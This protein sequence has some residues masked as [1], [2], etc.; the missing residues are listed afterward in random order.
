MFCVLLRILVEVVLPLCLD[1]V[2]VFYSPNRL[3]HYHKIVCVISKTLFGE[4]YPSA[5][6]QSVYSTAPTDRALLGEVLPLSSDA[7][8]V[9]YNHNRLGPHWGSL[10][11]LQRFSRC[12]L[13][14]QQTKPSLGKSHPSAQM[15]SVYSTTTTNS[16][17]TGEVLP[18]CRDSVGVFYSHNRLSPPWVSLTPQ[19]RCSRCI[20]QPQQTRPSLGKSYPSAKIQSVYSTAPMDWAL[21]GEVLPLC[22]DAVGV[23]YNHNKLGPHWGS[24]TPLQ[25]FSRC[26]LQPQQTKP[27]LGKSHPSAQM[28]SVYSTTTTNSALTGEVLPLCRDSVGVFYSHNRLSPPWVSLTP[29]LRCSRCILQPQQTRPSLGKSY[30]SA[31]IQSVYSTAPM[32]W[33]LLGEVLPLCRDA[34]GVFYN[35]N[36][37]GPHWGSL[38]PLQRFS[39]CILQ[40]QQTKPSLGKSHP[41][42]QM[43]S[44]YS[45]T[46][47]NSALT[48]EVLPLCRDSVGVFY[49]HNRLSPPW[50]SLTPQLRCSRCILQPQQTRPSLGKSYPYAEIQSVYSTTTTDSA[51]TGEVLPLCKDSVGVFYSPNGLG[52]PWGSLTPLQ[53]C[54][55]CILQ[56]QQTRPSLGKSYPSAEIQSVYSTATTD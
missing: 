32:D 2:G 53:R 45:T 31:K 3:G 35:H 43:Q 17:L 15:Q 5:E 34:V 38:T 20:L 24:L 6:M 7:V 22:R 13:Q 51:L 56:P 30:P 42:A 1:V 21:L 8:G 25:R 14:P 11:P 18:L 36:K 49:S 33:A 39:R 52:S 23:F 10:T 37:L 47:T 26:I 54:S 48:G 27:S 50:V 41:S 46:T 44:V 9:F 29:Q 55:R 28:Q 19:L 40:P 4:S 12:I 16:A